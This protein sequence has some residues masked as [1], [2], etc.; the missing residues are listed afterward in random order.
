MTALYSGN[1]V[2][3]NN[4]ADMVRN[5]YVNVMVVHMG[6]SALIILNK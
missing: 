4:E 3:N 2:N 6:M 5:K 1:T